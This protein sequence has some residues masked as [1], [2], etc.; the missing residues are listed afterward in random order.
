MLR[1]SSLH[2]D[3]GL[4]LTLDNVNS[5]LDRGALVGRLCESRTEPWERLKALL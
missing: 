4:D 2:H 5:S 1:V 3:A